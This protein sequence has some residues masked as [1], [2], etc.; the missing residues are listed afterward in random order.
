MNA[1]DF[2]RSKELFFTKHLINGNDEKILLE[3]LLDEYVDVVNKNLNLPSIIKSCDTC[4]NLSDCRFWAEAP[5]NG[6]TC[7]FYIEHV[8]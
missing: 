2:L 1:K 4:K 6:K 3:E 5:E 7:N 8:L